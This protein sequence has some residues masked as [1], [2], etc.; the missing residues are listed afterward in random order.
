MVPVANSMHNVANIN[1]ITNNNAITVLLL[2]CFST[3]SPPSI[4]LYHIFTK[5]NR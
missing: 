1:I 5:I 4:K 3:F 2:F